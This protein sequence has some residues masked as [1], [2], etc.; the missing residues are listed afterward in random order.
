MQVY[1]PTG[2]TKKT[3]K[4]EKQ[5]NL[6]QHIPQFPHSKVKTLI[7]KKHN[8]DTHKSKQPKNHTKTKLSQAPHV[9]SHKGEINT[10]FKKKKKKN[11]HT[12]TNCRVKRDTQKKFRTEKVKLTLNREE[13]ICGW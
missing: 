12:H 3:N 13:R 7:R 11:T 1:H 4:T 2:S 10:G 9:Q 8:P 5:K 6:N